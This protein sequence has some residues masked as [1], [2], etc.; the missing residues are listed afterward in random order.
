VG[1]PADLVL[2]DPEAEWKLEKEVLK[3]KSKNTPLIGRTFKG[4]IVGTFLG[5]RW[6][7]NI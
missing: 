4:R 7:K 2:F 3:S 5:G 6:I 1:E